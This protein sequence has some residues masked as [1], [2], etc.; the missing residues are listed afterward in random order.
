MSASS[1]R[2]SAVILQALWSQGRNQW[3]VNI[4]LIRVLRSSFKMGRLWRRWDVWI[5]WKKLKS[6]QVSFNV[7]T[8]SQQLAPTYFQFWCAVKKL[9][10]THCTTPKKPHHYAAITLTCEYLW[11]PSVRWILKFEECSFHVGEERRGVSATEPSQKKKCLTSPSVFLQLL[12]DHLSFRLQTSLGEG[13]REF[14]KDATAECLSR[15]G[16]AENSFFTAA[17]WN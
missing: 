12:P 17:F 11:E 16:K 7:E 14:D 9:S 13:T 5:E 15:T 2:G 8:A 10:R 6:S 1:E 3:R 4:L